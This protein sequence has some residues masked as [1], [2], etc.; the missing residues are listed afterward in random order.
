MNARR[1]YL[2]SRG[3]QVTPWPP[4]ITPMGDIGKGIME[5]LLNAKPQSNLADLA[6]QFPEGVQ[7]ANLGWKTPFLWEADPRRALEIWR[8]NRALIVLLHEELPE[9]IPGIQ[10]ICQRAFRHRD[11]DILRAVYYPAEDA[12]VHVIKKLVRSRQTKPTFRLLRM[13]WLDPKKRNWLLHLKRITSDV[14]AVMGMPEASWQM[15][16]HAQQSGEAHREVTF[17]LQ[18]LSSEWN[19]SNPGKPWPFGNMPFD[20]VH[21]AIYRLSSRRL[22]NTPF[23]PPPLP[24]TNSIYAVAGWA[25]LVSEGRA[26]HNCVLSYHRQILAGECYVYSLRRDLCRCTV[27]LR[28]AAQGWLLL[29]IKSHRNHGPSIQAFDEVMAWLRSNQPFLD[30]GLLDVRTDRELDDWFDEEMQ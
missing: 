5:A 23:P 13:Y 6:E 1:R 30:P 8:R 11:R 3:V 24:N 14:L 12:F 9:D 18:L 7:E 2:V 26:L 29:D 28:K 16:E 25:G 10:A 15:L 19:L 27:L 20:S 22:S 17:G 21:P 4:S